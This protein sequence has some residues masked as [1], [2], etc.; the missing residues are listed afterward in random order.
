MGTFTCFYES[1]S[2]IV[3]YD[4]KALEKL[5]LYARHLRPV[6]REKQPDEDDVDLSNVVLSH[7]RLSKIRQQDIQLQE[8]TAEY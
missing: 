8:N 2:Q 1:M 3:E 6:L 4:N 5:S 7:Y